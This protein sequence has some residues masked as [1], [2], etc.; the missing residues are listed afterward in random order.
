[1]SFRRTMSFMFTALILLLST[2]ATGATGIRAPLGDSYLSPVDAT[3]NGSKTIIGVETATLEADLIDETTCDSDDD[4]THSV[5][6]GFSLDSSATL[7]LD[8]AGSLYTSAEYATRLSVMSLYSISGV[9][10]THLICGSGYGARINEYDLAEGSYRVRIAYEDTAPLTGPSQARLS[11]R[12]RQYDNLLA[13]PFFDESLGIRWKVQNDPSGTKI[14]R[15][16]AVSCTVRFD[17]VAGGAIVATSRFPENMKVKKGD[18][19]WFTVSLNG[20]PVGGSTVKLKIKIIYSDGTPATTASVTRTFI[21]TATGSSP[22]TSLGYFNAEIRSKA[23]SKIKA[24]IISP[25]ADDTFNARLTFLSVEAGGNVRVA[26]ALP[27][28]APAAK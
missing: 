1:M 5:W 15:T 9:N 10:L 22:M 7:D 16:C 26:A 17:G 2:A 3:L 25:Q 18:I 19:V 23:V 24:S 14:V 21:Q 27:L 8:N 28:P 6:F 20:T 13:D 4:S 12:V 11:I